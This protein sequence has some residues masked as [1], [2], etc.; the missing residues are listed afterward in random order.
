MM[1]NSIS[2]ISD[3]ATSQLDI[4]AEHNTEQKATRA[5]EETASGEGSKPDQNSGDIFLKHSLKS[6]DDPENSIFLTYNSKGQFTRAAPQFADSTFLAYDINSSA[7]QPAP[8][9][10]TGEDQQRSIDIIV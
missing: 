10:I 6:P 8:T 2:S 7:D 4:K 5:I 1:T 3:I 9:D